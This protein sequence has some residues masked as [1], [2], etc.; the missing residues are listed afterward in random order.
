MK[1]YLPSY[2]ST[3]AHGEFHYASRS[4]AVHESLQG[5]KLDSESLKRLGIKESTLPDALSFASY[6]REYEKI[7]PNIPLTEFDAP[8]IPAIIDCYRSLLIG[9]DHLLFGLA[10][11]CINAVIAVLP[12]KSYLE[13]YEKNVLSSLKGARIPFHNNV[14]N[15][16]EKRLL[17]MSISDTFALLAVSEHAFLVTI[18]QLAGS[19]ESTNDNAISKKC[20]DVIG[21]VGS[22][23]N[24][25]S[26]IWF[27]PR[28][29]EDGLEAVQ[30]FNECN[31]VTYLR[32]TQA[33]ICEHIENMNAI[34][35]YKNS[36]I[37]EYEKLK[38]KKDARSK[39]RKRELMKSFGETEKIRKILDCP[40]VHRLLEMAH[41]Y[42]PMIG[43]G[44]RITELE[45]ERGH[46]ALKRSIRNSNNHNSHIQ[47]ISAT[48]CNDWQGRMTMLLAS[49]TDQNGEK[50]RA[51]FRLIFGREEIAARS[52]VLTSGDEKR[53]AQAIGPG[54]HLLKLLNIQNLTVL[55]NSNTDRAQMY[56]SGASSEFSKIM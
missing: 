53:L 51:L 50:K 37:R 4:S 22:L 3:E 38:G 46:Q 32:Q 14:V 30:K 48:V 52:G 5:C 1:L 43:S 49:D 23:Q 16:S 7:L 44:S 10:K 39:T 18:I 13:S 17:P 20:L 31:G 25:S 40:N 19:E 35:S 15:F 54:T 21:L 28:V 33:L 42:L 11:N 41:V 2:M 12:T 24:I 26:R 47:A 45:F 9:P 29:I 56:W 36:K 6:L 34:S 27:R 8:V 55:S